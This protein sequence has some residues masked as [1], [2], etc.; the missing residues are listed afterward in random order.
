MQR[1][2]SHST[3]HPPPGRR[4][5]QLGSTHPTPNKAHLDD[6]QFAAVLR[7]ELVQHRQQHAAGAAPGSAEIDEGE[8]LPRGAPL[9]DAPQLGLA[10]GQ[11]MHATVGIVG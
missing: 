7:G 5:Q 4:Q 2:T 1:S 10:L 6:S 8:L 3:A 9:Q 11:C